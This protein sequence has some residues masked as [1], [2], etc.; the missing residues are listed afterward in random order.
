MNIL[1]NVMERQHSIID[2]M[3]PAQDQPSA[4]HTLLRLSVKDD[5]YG[6]APVFIGSCMVY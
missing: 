3:Y 5:G 1:V 2:D 4:C 6:I